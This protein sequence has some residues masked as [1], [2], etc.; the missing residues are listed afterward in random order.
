MLLSYSSSKIPRAINSLSRVTLAASWRSDRVPIFKS[1]GETGKGNSA[2]L[3]SFYGTSQLT[4]SFA[5]GQHVAAALARPTRNAR[6]DRAILGVEVVIRC[7]IGVFLAV[8]VV[9]LVGEG[10]VK[11][12][13]GP[14]VAVFLVGLDLEDLGALG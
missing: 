4:D 11:H 2:S 9:A 5:A 3:P 7:A 1:L 6:R 8:L 14:L 10:E 13:A 12:A